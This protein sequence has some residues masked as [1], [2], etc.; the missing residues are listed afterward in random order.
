MI[1]AYQSKYNT[2]K[3]EVMIALLFQG[4]SWS[5]IVLIYIIDLKLT[6]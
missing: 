5:L 6:L 4:E 3:L 1:S 2:N